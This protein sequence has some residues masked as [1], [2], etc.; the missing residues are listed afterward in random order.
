MKIDAGIKHD[1]TGQKII[2][3]RLK[4]YSRKNNHLDVT[5]LHFIYYN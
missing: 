5:F 2:L 3:R 4:M 1:S